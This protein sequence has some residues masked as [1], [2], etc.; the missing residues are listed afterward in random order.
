[1]NRPLARLL[2]LL[3]ALGALIVPVAGCGSAK[4]D[5]GADPLDNALGYVPPKSPLVISFTTDPKGSQFQA[6]KKIVEKFPFAN[7]IEQSLKSSLQSQSVNYDR[8][9]K[10]LLGNPFV[11]AATNVKSLQNNSSGNQDFVGAIQAKDGKKLQD[12][13]KKEKATED[14]SKD[15][16]KIYKDKSGSPFA[17]KDDVLIVAGSRALLDKALAARGSDSRLTES[18]FD[19]STEGLPKDSAVRLSTD[20]EALLATDPNAA[21]ARKV[22]W[23]KALRTLGLSASVVNDKIDVDFNLA[24]DSSG[25]T[26]AD[27]PIASG[28]QTPDVIKR[29]GEIGFGLRNPGQVV[30]FAENAGQ[31]VNPS[32]FGSYETAKKTVEAQLKINIQKDVI[33]QLENGVSVAVAPTRGKVAV[34]GKVKDASAFRKSLAKVNKILPAVIQSS[35]GSKPKVS[36]S[37]GLYVA[38]TPSRT[39]SYGLVGDTFVFSDSAAAARAVAKAPTATV[40]GAK[41]SLAM[42][43]DAEQVVVQALKRIGASGQGQQLGLGAALGGSLFAGPLGDLTGSAKADTSG[44]TGQVSLAFD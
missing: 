19:K 43:A 36:Y 15:G 20:V 32:Q 41:G 40:P 24:T 7:Q 35:T 44:I 13:V 16:A 3:L 26:D 12:A 8:D 23:V 25:L 14:G 4:K 10:P 31:A 9:L 38:K 6:A 27:L 42:Q 5:T 1:M 18:D 17:I 11:V 29:K 34:K 28:D 21:R 2:A 37:G 22:K 39:Y 30:T 33:D